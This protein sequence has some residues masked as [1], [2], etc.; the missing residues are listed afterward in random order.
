MNSSARRL[1]SAYS[2]MS[3]SESRNDER[4]WKQLSC[5][6][7]PEG[8]WPPASHSAR[9]ILVSAQ[10][11]APGLAV[12]RSAGKRRAENSVRSPGN[13]IK[14]HSKLFLKQPSIT[15]DFQKY[16]YCALRVLRAS[17]TATT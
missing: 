6:S 7:M 1:K 12:D 3:L 11:E 10:A 17:L 15:Y 5:G 4:Q 16:T 8:S 14:S 2:R 9:S 13:L